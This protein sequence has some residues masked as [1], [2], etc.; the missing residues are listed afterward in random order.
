MRSAIAILAMLLFAESAHDTDADSKL[1]EAFLRSY[2][3]GEYDLIGRKVD[4]TETYTG[5]VTLPDERGTRREGSGL[6]IETIG[7]CLK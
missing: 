3:A 7:L 4:S 2:L 1:D 6:S 5:H